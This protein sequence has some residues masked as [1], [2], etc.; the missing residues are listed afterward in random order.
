MNSKD[1]EFGREN[2]KFSLILRTETDYKDDEQLDKKTVILKSKRE[3][4]PE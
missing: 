4:K 3:L 2:E 1:T